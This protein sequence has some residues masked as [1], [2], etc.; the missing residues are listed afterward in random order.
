MSLAVG[1]SASNNIETMLMV[2]IDTGAGA[3]IGWLPYFEAVILLNPGILVQI[4]TCVGGKYS[5]ITMHRIVDAAKGVTT[6]DLSVAFQIRTRYRCYDGLRLHMTVG[7]GMNVSV[8]FIVSNTWMK[9]IRAVIDY[10]AAKI[11]VPL[12]D[13]V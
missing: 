7:L 3:M 4:Y 13:D 8:N 5:P 10:G 11:C 9:G 1:D 6:T 12:Q 2:L